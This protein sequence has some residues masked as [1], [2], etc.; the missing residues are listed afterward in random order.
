MDYYFITPAE[1]YLPKGHR[2][3]GIVRHK[4]SNISIEFSDNLLTT[5]DL[6]PYFEHCNTPA[7]A[8]NFGCTKAQ[9]LKNPNIIKFTPDSHPEYFI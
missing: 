2:K 8:W 1:G 6:K 4:G 3:Y 9:L 5:A 7:K